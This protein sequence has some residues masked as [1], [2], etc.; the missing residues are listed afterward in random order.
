[1]NSDQ[2][3]QINCRHSS[4][5]DPKT[6]SP[7]EDNPNQHDERQLEVIQKILLHQ[8]WRSPIVVSANSGKVVCGHGR[9]A[10]ALAMNLAEVPVDE[11]NFES[12][13]DEIAHMI[14]DNRLAS[15]AELDYEKV[16]DLLR[17]LDASQVDLDMTAFAEWEREPLLNA[18]WEPPD[19]VSDRDIPQNNSITLTTEQREVFERAASKLRDDE[20]DSEMSDGRCV[21]LI[22]ADFMA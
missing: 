13:E 21:E 15:M 10:A 20:D 2:T 7:R 8:G 18:L 5:T 6:L 4:L 9:L 3:P 19:E 22:C 11:Q 17:E 1:M 12:E 16:G 14:A